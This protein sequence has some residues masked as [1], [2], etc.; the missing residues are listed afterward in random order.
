MA[1]P[2][3]IPLMLEDRLQAARLTATV[4]FTDLAGF[5]SFSAGM[6]PDEVF[7][8]LNHYFAWSGEVIGRYRGYTNKTMGDGA[9]ALFG[10]PEPTPSH[11]T[12]AALTA[13]TLQAEIG[14]NI[15]LPLRIGISSGVITAG[16]LGP[17][18]KSLYDVLGETVNLAQRMESIAPKGGIVASPAAAELLRPYFLL[19]ANPEQEIDGLRRM[20]SHRVTGLR[21]LVDDPRRLDPT[22]RI[23]ATA[24]ALT[25]EIEA[26][27]R[28]N[29]DR[30]N[31]V[32]IQARD[33][34]FYHNETVAIIALAL[35]RDLKS[36]VDE[37]KLIRFAL[38]HDIGKRAVD[39]K[40]L[41]QRGLSPE[42][43][44]RLRADLEARTIE[45]LD[46]LDSADL[47]ES[48]RELY[49][50]EAQALND[51]DALTEI[52]AVADIY[53]ALTAPKFYKGTPWSIRGA[54]ED[55]LRTPFALARPRPILQA[56]AELMRPAAAAMTAGRANR[57]ILD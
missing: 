29:F 12:D 40:R 43:R 19:E 48:V 26:F 57:P 42:E 10:V 36:P 6:E 31:F 8:H 51:A 9:M 33:G 13:L 16:M 44:A 23:A 50:L 4:M 37:T 56:F 25:D 11:A 3:L 30:V 49:R 54:L 1:P 18:N 47:A 34:A 38:L 41:N 5:T 2:E 20:A 35:A 17:R 55:I 7:A 28:A 24:A 32:S 21:K 15:S 52:V 27:K 46:Q 14:A 45:T 22:S 53:D 39:P